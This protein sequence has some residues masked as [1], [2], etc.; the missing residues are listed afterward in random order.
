MKALVTGVTGQDGSYLTEYLL[1]C[2]YEVHAFVRRFETLENIKNIV[3]DIHQYDIDINDLGSILMALREVRP[4]EIYHLASQ[5]FVGASFNSPILTGEVTGLGTLRILE[6]CRLLG[7]DCRIYNAASSE[8]YGGGEDL[9]ESSP[10]QPKSPYG[11][12][13]LFSYWMCR[14]YR[15]AYGMHVSNGI[16]FNHES[17]R[18]GIEF[19]TR[20]ISD[21][22]AK[23]KLG[24]Q[25][26]ISLGNVKAVRDWGYTPDYV[27]GMVAL[28]K[29]D[30][31]D[32]VVMCSGKPHSVMDFAEEAFRAAG[33]GDAAD[34]I[35]VDVARRRP[36]D[37]DVLTG[38]PA[39]A[40][41]LLGWQARTQFKELV[42]IMVDSDISLQRDSDPIEHRA[43]R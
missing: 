40:K 25:K 18:R 34:Y 41:S 36:L 4:D 3:N 7:L 27:K 23:I 22:V 39:K 24:K 42:R 12:A 8:M 38:N 43:M 26:R 35:D 32:D 33:M 1:S 29:L 37:I 11:V 2:G 20:R 16:L 14:N 15:E 10:L 19:V 17:P 21:G 28:L 31:A 13:K 6:A 30:Q 9:S 5:S